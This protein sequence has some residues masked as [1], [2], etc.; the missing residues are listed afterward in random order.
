MM[1]RGLVVCWLVPYDHDCYLK[2][3]AILNPTILDPVI[4]PA[5][6]LLLLARP[7]WLFRPVF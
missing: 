5:V 3:Q 6:Y 4:R 7:H 1:L 2:A